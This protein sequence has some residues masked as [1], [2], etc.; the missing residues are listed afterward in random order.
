M[1]GFHTSTVA[2]RLLVLAWGELAL[3][4]RLLPIDGH[5]FPSL[6]FQSLA[7]MHSAPGGMAI[8]VLHTCRISRSP[9]LQTF[10]WIAYAQFCMV[11]V[12]VQH[13]HMLLT[14]YKVV[15]YVLVFD[16]LFEATLHSRLLN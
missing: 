10:E 3:R 4:L 16:Q 11:G 12:F 9:F 14:Q 8:S 5:V 15:L 6:I 13:I 2:H 7:W 1:I